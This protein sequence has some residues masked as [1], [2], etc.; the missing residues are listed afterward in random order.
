MTCKEKDVRSL[1]TYTAL[2]KAKH[3]MAMDRLFIETLPTHVRCVYRGDSS[4]P[5]GGELFK[6]WSTHG[7]M[8]FDTEFSVA[9]S[10]L[11][12]RMELLWDDFVSTHSHD[13]ENSSMKSIWTIKALIRELEVENDK[14]TNLESHLEEELAR[15][16]HDQW[17]EW[18]VHMFKC[19]GEF[20]DTLRGVQFVIYP[21]FVER[22]CRQMATKYQDLTEKEKDSDRRVSSGVLDLVKEYALDKKGV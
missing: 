18:M 7:N 2:D 5:L 8:K 9:I 1:K 16:T 14:S 13:V 20:S 22:W 17:S 12:H 6:W 10:W 3:L 11:N 21:E 4:P 15:L 19:C